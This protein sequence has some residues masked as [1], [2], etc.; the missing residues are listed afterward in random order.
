MALYTGQINV[1]TTPQQIDNTSTNPFRLVVHNA[2]ASDSIY[3][4]NSDVTVT[5]G[6]DLHAKST[7]TLELP[8]MTYLWVV[9]KTSN[10][11]LHWMHI[12]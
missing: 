7:L 5:T 6:L 11:K 1:S 12:S 4:G 3:I 10:H 9:G 2:S 8:P